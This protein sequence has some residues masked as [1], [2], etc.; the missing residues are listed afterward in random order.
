MKTTLLKYIVCPAHKR[1]LRTDSDGV[2]GEVRDGELICEQGCRYP[3][4][5]GVPRFVELEQLPSESRE[6]CDSFSAKWRRIPNFGFEKGSKTFYHQWYLNRY[7]F[8]DVANLGTFL[9][10]RRMVLDA[11]TGPGRDA[12][13]YGQNTTGQVFAVDFS[14]S[15]DVAYSHVGHLPNVHV[16][17]ADLMDLPFPDG[18]FDYIASDGVLHHTPDTARAFQAL[19]R[20]LGPD[21]E[22]AA[23]VYAR[24]GPIREFSDDLIRRHYASDAASDEECYALSRAM[25]S[26]GRSLSDLNVEVEVP[27]DIEILGIKAGR[28]NLQRLFYWNICKCYW[29]DELDFETNVMT[30]FDWYRPRYAHRHTPDEVQQWCDGLG[31]KIVHFDVIESGISVRAK[32][33][34]REG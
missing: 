16:L 33:N 22:I 5:N 26:F 18:V 17:Q 4:R 3:I 6:T 32:K 12:M 14:D 30:N 15:V 21:G 24:K 9:A 31:L 7:G 13:L 25:T 29:N 19:C 23:Y 1:P 34:G 10:T 8:G 20:H 27:E 11:G 2:N 28:H